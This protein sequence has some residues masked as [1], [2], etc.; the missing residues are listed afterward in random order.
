MLDVGG[1]RVQKFD[2]NG[3]FIDKWHVNIRGDSYMTIDEFNRIYVA[4]NNYRELIVY[5][6]EGNLK[7]RIIIPEDTI[8]AGSYIFVQKNQFFA[9]NCQKHNIKVFNLEY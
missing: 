1:C 5:D 8:S 4:E 3:V 7:N 2:N 9:S 6:T